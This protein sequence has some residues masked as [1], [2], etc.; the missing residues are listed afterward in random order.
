MKRLTL[1]L[2]LVLTAP[3]FVSSAQAKGGTPQNHH[4]VKDGSPV[5]DKTRKQCVK[6]G[7]KWEKDTAAPNASPEGDKKTAPD[8][9]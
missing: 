5:P 4:C 9:K 6:E 8:A 3:M 2:T 1:V 7:G